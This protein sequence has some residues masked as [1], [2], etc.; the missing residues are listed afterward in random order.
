MRSLTW[1]RDD[2]LRVWNKRLENRKIKVRLEFPN[3][4]SRAGT[5]DMLNFNHNPF[6]VKYYCH[7]SARSTNQSTLRILPLIKH[8]AIGQRTLCHGWAKQISGVGNSGNLRC[9]QVYVLRIEF[10]PDSGAC[11]NES[12]DYHQKKI[13]HITIPYLSLAP[14]VNKTLRTL[15]RAPRDNMTR[16][17]FCGLC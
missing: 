2:R 6:A 5:R 11:C 9:K 7:V 17:S 12:Y 15:A 10:I 13:A 16:R 1:V 4:Y 8:S 14:R 3:A